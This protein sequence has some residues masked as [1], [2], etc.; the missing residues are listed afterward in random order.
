[1]PLLHVPLAVVFPSRVPAG[2]RVDPFVSLRDLPSTILHLTGVSELAR[3]PGRS[4]ARFWEDPAGM[5]GVGDEPIVSEVLRARDVYPDSYPGR[6]GS[7]GAVVFHRMQYILNRGDGREELY[8]LAR[9][10]E[11]LVD[12]SAAQPDRVAEYR[13]Y[14][15][16]AK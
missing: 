3:F 1:M 7:M 15:T 13:A 8:D 11:A 9:D 16:G 14:L 5:G 12:L 4:L 10:P 6:K 2:R